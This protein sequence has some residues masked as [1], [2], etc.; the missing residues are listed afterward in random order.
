MKIW[1][2]MMSCF[3]LGATDVQAQKYDI[4]A[5][6][7]SAEMGSAKYQLLLGYF[8][9]SGKHVEKDCD[10]SFKWLNKAAQNGSSMALYFLGRSYERGCGVEKDVRKALD[11]YHEAAADSVTEAMVELGKQYLY[12]SELVKRDW[13]KSAFM[14]LQAASLGDEYAQLECA[15]YYFNGWG[16]TKDVVK[17]RECLQ[18]VIDNGEDYQEQAKQLLK[19]TQKPDTFK[20]Y[21]FEFRMIPILLREVKSDRQIEYVLSDITSL[22]ARLDGYIISHYEWDWNEMTV[23]RIPLDAGR[24]ILL[25][26]M[27]DP[28]ESPFCKY[29][30]AVLDKVQGRF[31]YFTFEKSSNNNWFFCGV[32]EKLSHLNYGKAKN[33]PSKEY[34]LEFVK[35]KVDH[36]GNY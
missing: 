34:F 2:I 32:S 14:M 11:Y 20:L 29:M 4:K 6:T 26:T 13:E 33:G 27:P 22:K 24:D 1:A 25:Y 35:D 16:V 12:G 9:Q 28:K 36:V 23:E 10:A 17:A 3:L 7:D 21:E 31:A 18:D 5:I 15:S 19:N 30:A 8:Y